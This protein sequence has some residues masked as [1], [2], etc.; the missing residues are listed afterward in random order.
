M[1]ATLF[2]AV[3]PSKFL[4]MFFILSIAALVGCS[5]HPVTTEPTAQA[6]EPEKIP[7]LTLTEAQLRAAQ[8]S[9]VTYVL[10]MD[11]TDA[12]TF[13][14]TE[15]IEFDWRASTQDLLLDFH[16]GEISK[17]KVNGEQVVAAYNGLRLSLPPGLFH[18][19]RNKIN[20]DFKREYSTDGKGLTRF[21]DPEDRQVYLHTQFEAYDAN[22]MFP[23]FD[24]PDLKAT[25]TLTLKAPGDWKVISATREK[26]VES[27][28]EIKTWKFPTS[29]LFSTY[30]F[31]LHAGPYHVWEDRSTDIPLRLFA[32]EK[33]APYVDA[34]EWFHFTKQGFAF[35]NKYFGTKYPFHKYDQVIAP[36]FNAGAMENVAAVAFSEFLVT[37]GPK[38]ISERRNLASI[39]LHEMAH[40]WFGDLVTMK[41]WNDLWLNESFATYMSALAMVSN[42]EFKKEWS[43]FN[44]QKA[45]AMWE[46][47]LITTH[48]I[49]GQVPDLLTA[50]ASFDAI[51]YGKGASVLKQLHYLIGDKAFQAGLSE[52]FKTYAGFNTQ[53]SDFIQS[54]AKASKRNLEAWQSEWLTTAGVDTIQVDYECKAN[55]I[56]RISILQTADP[57]QPTLRSHALAL[58]LIQVQGGVARVQKNIHIEI[59]GEKTNLDKLKGTNCPEA[60]YPNGEDHGYVKVALDK[61]SLKNLRHAQIQDELLR[62]QIWTTYW[63]MVRDAKMSFV[64][65]GEMA[66]AA[67]P[68]ERDP[69]ILE[70]LLRALANPYRASVLN[71][72][73]W[74]QLE[75]FSAFL[76]FREKSESLAWQQL[77]SADSSLQKYWFQFLISTAESSES[78]KR[79]LSILKGPKDWH[80]LK[81]DQDM[82]WSLLVRLS[83]LGH[84]EAKSLAVKEASVDPSFNGKLGRLSS[85]AAWPSLDEKNKWLQEFKKYK[86]EYTFTE[87]REI[88][89]SL[90]PVQQLGL[91]LQYS[92]NFYKDL[93]ALLKVKTSEEL[94]LFSVLEPFSC[95]KKGVKISENF[96]EEHKSDI[97]PVLRKH[98]LMNSDNNRKCERS[99]EYAKYDLEHSDQ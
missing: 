93:S 89:Y 81:I 65:F 94:G 61:R 88:F 58:S 67:A 77:S 33:L 63:L 85:E 71:F 99:L 42:T 27:K 64:Q 82:R 31:S 84:P 10:S 24:Q 17:L 40:M 46:D 74:G 60:F 95:T 20:L 80:G 66:L 72:Y 76:K 52:Y 48:P 90:F 3:R 7:N 19:G 16:Q 91:N 21:V 14:G 47:Q 6:T 98:L 12:K 44:S 28:G 1:V 43:S 29:D 22:R 56:S 8:I 35:Y 38:N 59:Q 87:F 73:H 41:W 86:S 18:I 78:Q 57:S 4:Q 25:F 45:G 13:T 70:F 23:C 69:T 97:D 96:M 75:K 62:K 30:L 92:E 51:T 53:R 32:R 83:V 49:E 37:R 2:L 9:H 54:L 15:V 39:I 5:S 36:A 68:S 50:E 55:K 79:L 26:D 11:I 34:K